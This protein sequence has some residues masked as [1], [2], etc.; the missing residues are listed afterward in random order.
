MA[1]QFSTHSDIIHLFGPLDDHI[2]AEI[3]GLRPTIDDLEVAAAY[4]AGMTDVLG[5]ARLPLSGTAA[6]VYEIVQRDELLE[7]EDR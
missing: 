3:L 4:R 5:E 2:A 6:R 1:S 7:E